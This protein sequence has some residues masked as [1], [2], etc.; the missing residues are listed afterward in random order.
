MT[1]AYRL[2][3]ESGHLGFSPEALSNSPRIH[4][5]SWLHGRRGHGDEVAK[6]S[7]LSARLYAGRY[8]VPQKG[9]IFFLSARLRAGR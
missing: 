2:R 3:G 6:H 9:N 4:V 5:M 7:F 1:V 8:A